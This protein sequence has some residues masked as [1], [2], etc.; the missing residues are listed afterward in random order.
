MRFKIAGFLVTVV[1]LAFVGSVNAGTAKLSYTHFQNGTLALVTAEYVAAPG[2]ANVAT[3]TVQATPAGAVVRV[4]DAGANV[5]AGRGFTSIGDGEAIATVDEAP[6]N[7]VVARLS[8]G[9]RADR[10]V[11][12]LPDDVDAADAVLVGGSGSDELVVSQRHSGAVTLLGGGGSDL[13]D[14][15]PGGGAASYVDHVRPVRVDLDG[16]D[17][18]GSL[19]ERDRLRNITIVWGSPRNDLIAGSSGSDRLFGRGGSDTIHGRGG[20]DT[21]DG[22]WGADRIV[23]G[24]GLDWIGGGAGNDVLYARDGVRD[25][26][27]GRSGTDRAALD[28]IDVARGV[29]RR[30]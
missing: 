30:L 26:V 2:E 8:L 25:L 22:E 7:G 11:V 28:T 21:I 19:G 9:D 13:L 3:M 1:T 24:R 29:E 16:V 18:D 27:Y 12:D 23:G 5:T 20:N 4:Q 10:G 14:G 6:A 17:D 15:G